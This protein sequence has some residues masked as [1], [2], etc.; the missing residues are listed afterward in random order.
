MYSDRIID[1]VRDLLHGQM[2]VGVGDKDDSGIIIHD[3]VVADKVRG[4]ADVA[5]LT[6]VTELGVELG[7]DA[8]CA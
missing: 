5:G 3:K 6:V 2:A 8:G 1:S 4:D 7:A